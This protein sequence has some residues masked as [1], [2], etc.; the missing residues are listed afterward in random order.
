MQFSRLQ[1]TLNAFCSAVGKTELEP[2]S[3]CCG[4]RQLQ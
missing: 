4:T 3:T 1:Q 2:Y